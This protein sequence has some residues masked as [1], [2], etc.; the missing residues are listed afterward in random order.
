MHDFGCV[1]WTNPVTG[2]TIMD[3]KVF[4]QISG[5]SFC[6][7][8]Y[9]KTPGGD[10]CNDDQRACSC[11]EL[12]TWDKIVKCGRYLSGMV[13][14]NVISKTHCVYQFIRF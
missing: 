13:M 4:H 7:T 10:P 1:R 8:C 2:D 9:D 12:T 6:V 5:S 11:S 14:M 3:Y